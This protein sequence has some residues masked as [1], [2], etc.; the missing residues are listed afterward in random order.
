[1]EL[2]GS[3]YQYK[4]IAGDRTAWAEA[5]RWWRLAADKGSKSAQGSLTFIDTYLKEQAAPKATPEQVAAAIKETLPQPGG[6]RGIGWAYLWPSSG[7]PLNQAE[8][9]RW[10]E[11]AAAGGDAD[12]MDDLGQQY[13]SGSWGFPMDHRKAVE[14]LR[15]AAAKGNTNAM[16]TLGILHEE[17]RAGL[18]WS[19]SEAKSW[20]ERAKQ[21]GEPRGDESLA[22][23]GGAHLQ[24]RAGPR[25]AS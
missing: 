16:L 4:A 12:A 25:T 14:W 18:P 9:R 24:G 1:M 20:Y 5:R 19:L 15:R 2:A 8:G 21:A 10:L 23:L 13:L 7:F 17:G 11:R 22:M 3:A 6:A